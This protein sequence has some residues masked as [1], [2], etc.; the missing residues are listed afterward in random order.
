MK[1]VIDGDYLFDYWH[2]LLLFS[3]K[4]KLNQILPVTKE[5]IKFCLV[6]KTASCSFK[7]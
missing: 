2:I 5:K 6:K 7:L 3:L 1:Y 4:Q